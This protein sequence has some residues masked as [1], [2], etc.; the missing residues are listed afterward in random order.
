MKGSSVSIAG[1]MAVVTLAAIDCL[2]LRWSYV[3]ASRTNLLLLG[4]LPILDALAVGAWLGGRDLIKRRR[5]SSSLTGF[6][7][8]GWAASAVYAIA[9]VFPTPLAESYAQAVLA[10]VDWLMGR[11]GGVYEDSPIGW[12]AFADTCASAS[13]SA[14]LLAFAW[15]G[16][17]LARR[18]D[19]WLARGAWLRPE[20]GRPSRIA[21]PRA[22]S[23]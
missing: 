5:C 7:A 15:S 8:F 11:L 3:P 12:R 10:P 2:A 23:D 6:H 19:V 9:F 16:S 21:R 1:G 20:E 4:L 14:P 22:A 17:R 18:F 13:L